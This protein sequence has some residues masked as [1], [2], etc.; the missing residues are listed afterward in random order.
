MGE[1]AKRAY[2]SPLREEQA[3]RT[4]QAV[5]AAARDLFLADGYAA[6]T[7]Q[8]VAARA[9]VATD[10][11]YHVFKTKRGL[12][13]SV[14]DVTIGGDD[15]DVALL[16][17]EGPQAMRREPDQRR[18][19]AM[20]A[21]AMTEQLER[22]RPLDDVLRQAAAI[23]PEVAALRDDLQ[24][25]QRRAAMTEVVGWVAAHGPL[26]AELSGEDAVAITWT[27]TSPEV[28]HML[29][30]AWRWPPERYRSWLEEAL[31][32]ALLPPLDRDPDRS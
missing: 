26:R 24:L 6:T 1:Q 13:K 19:I 23:D 12:L 32:H 2:R 14:L 25:R 9:G 18:Q 3:R 4:R 21:H 30:V 5:V 11:V 20:L 27:L 17:R 29:R 7:M 28:H 10:T 8:A 22:V 16:D 31:V 15:R